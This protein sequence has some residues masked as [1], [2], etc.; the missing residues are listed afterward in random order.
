MRNRAIHAT[1][2]PRVPRVVEALLRSLSPPTGLPAQGTWVGPV[3][4]LPRLSRS[5][6]LPV[7]ARVA[8]EVNEPACGSRHCAGCAG[9]AGDSGISPHNYPDE[10]WLHATI[11]A[12]GALTIVFASTA[13]WLVTD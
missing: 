12:L 8:P 13:L 7:A 9:R 11:T 10:L 6:D 3:I 4:N 2:V 5:F 1:R